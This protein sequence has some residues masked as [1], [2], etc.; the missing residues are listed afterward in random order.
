MLAKDLL[1]NEIPALRTSDTG[2]EALNWMEVFRISHLPIVNNEQFLGVISD[3]DIYDLNDPEAPLGNHDLSLKSP[4]AYMDQHVYEVMELTSRLKLTTVAVVDRQN[5]YKGLIRLSDLLHHFARL[6]AI[7][8]PGGIIVLEVNQNDYSVSEI[9]QIVEGN[10]AKILSL[11]VR[12]GGESTRLEVTLKINI[13]DVTSI[14]QTFNRYDYQVKASFMDVDENNE[15][16]ESRYDML[17]RY[18]NT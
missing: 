2:V 13:T 18:L 4:F 14:I 1:S 16:L 8:K 11:Y 6:T 17:M 12:G 3:T 5:R 10:N 15:L 7:E 9:A